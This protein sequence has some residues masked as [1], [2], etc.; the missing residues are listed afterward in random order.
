MSNHLLENVTIYWPV[1]NKPRASKHKDKPASWSVQLRTSDSNQVKAWKALGIKLKSHIAD[2]ADPE[3]YHYVNVYKKSVVKGE[4]RSRPT[5]VDSRG[6]PLDPAIIGNGSVA[7]VSLFEYQ[8]PSESSPTG[9]G[10]AFTVM[11]V[12]VT[13]LVKYVTKPRNDFKDLGYDT[14]T[15]GTSGEEPESAEFDDDPDESDEHVEHV[16]ETR[17]VTGT[18]QPKAPSAPTRRPPAAP[19]EDDDF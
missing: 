4:E 3:T 12:Q 8:Y 7:N 18:V 15:I 11:G 2:D 6:R 16:E 14:P 19:A 1:L 17:T 9:F 13:K 5:T 10:T